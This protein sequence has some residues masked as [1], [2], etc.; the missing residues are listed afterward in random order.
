MFC[1]IM[2]F[3][4]H[5]EP[6]ENIQTNQLIFPILISICVMFAINRYTYTSRFLLSHSASNACQN[7]DINFSNVYYFIEI[8]FSG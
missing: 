5:R 4:T 8:V 7:F 1:Y 3:I 2:R 6:V